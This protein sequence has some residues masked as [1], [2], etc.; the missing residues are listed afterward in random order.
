LSITHHHSILMFR[1]IF[2][3]LISCIFSIHISQIPGLRNYNENDGLNSSYTYRL[4]QDNNGFIWIG[5]DNGLFRFDG[6]E[7]K[8]YGKE[9]G[10]M[11]IEVID[12]E[13]LPNGEVFLIPYLNDFAYLKNEKII[14]LSFSR[15]LK[16]QFANSL[17]RT[18]RNGN[19][20]YLYSTNNP[21]SILTYE[22]G[23][24]KTQTVTLNY[25]Q[26]NVNAFKYDFHRNILYMRIILK[27]MS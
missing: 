6:K 16:N 8:Q 21:K 11:N 24:F 3:I 9:E 22:N 10:L 19:K 1:K 12:C 20:L 23:A 14:N 15:S 18:D 26:K 5:S 27:I 7:F 17:A 25:G 4:K 2:V 13:P